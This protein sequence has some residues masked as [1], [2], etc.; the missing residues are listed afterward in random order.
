M[1]ESEKL[2]EIARQWISLW[3]VPV[4]WELFN[5][6]HADDFE[7]CSSAGGEAS[8]AKKAAGG[9]APAAQ[10]PPGGR[11]VRRWG[12]WDIGG[13]LDAPGAR[14]GAAKPQQGA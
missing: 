12:E 5:A 2:A 1:T 13:H 7:D 14:A 6:L 4:D 3:S 8:A 9:G 11:I 10:T